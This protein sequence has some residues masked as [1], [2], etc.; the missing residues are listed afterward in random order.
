MHKK[1]IDPMT[2]RI[3]MKFSLQ[4]DLDAKLKREEQRFKARFAHID[5]EN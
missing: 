2:G 4:D 1:T 3:F 5:T